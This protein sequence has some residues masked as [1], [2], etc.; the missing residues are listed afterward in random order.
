[1]FA[2]LND[3]IQQGFGNACLA[4]VAKP[5]VPQALK[6]ERTLFER[7]VGLLHP[8][9]VLRV[10]LYVRVCVCACVCHLH[11][12]NEK[13]HNTPEERAV[14]KEWLKNALGAGKSQTKTTYKLF[15]HRNDWFVQVRVAA[16]SQ[17]TIEARFSAV[18][19]A[20]R[21]AYHA[22]TT[23]QAA[24]PCHG[25]VYM[26]VCAQVRVVM[27]RPDVI[28]GMRDKDSEDQGEQGEDNNQAPVDIPDA[29][30]HLEAGKL[31]CE[32]ARVARQHEC[33]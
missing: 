14:I 27:S 18:A 7:T 22:F 15:K 12:I 2:T 31:P 25:M 5:P 32:C 8:V 9:T 17:Q 29:V 1:M 24:Q 23:F 20:C 4:S 3:W 11:R 21:M 28:M 10:C 26:C 30:A 16:V 19:V 13:K 33:V 6:F